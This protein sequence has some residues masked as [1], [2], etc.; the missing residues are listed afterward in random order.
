MLSVESVDAAEDEVVDGGAHFVLLLV[1]LLLLPVGGIGLSASKDVGEVVL[2]EL[3]LRSEYAGI[4]EINHGKE[5]RQIILHR[6]SR[7][8][9]PPL[10]GQ[11]KQRLAGLVLPILESM[12]LIANQQ[13][14]T[15]LNPVEPPDVRSHGF[16]AGNQDVEHFGLDEYV[17]ILFYGLAIGFGKGYGF[18][19]AG[20]EPLDEFVVP[21]FD[22]RAG[23]YDDDAL[24]GRGCPGGNSSLE[25][26]VD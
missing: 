12:S 19:G 10:A 7:Q 8:Q 25:E 5:F 15:I 2:P 20:T 9:N 14:T 16:V 24:G 22:E 11:T 18:D 17:Q 21:V 6:S 3:L 13:I 1:H 26:G 23:T 4:D